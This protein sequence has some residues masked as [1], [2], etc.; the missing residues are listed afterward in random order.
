MEKQYWEVQS[1]HGGS[2][3]ITAAGTLAGGAV[4]FYIGNAVVN[5]NL[6]KY[7]DSDGRF[8]AGK[9]SLVKG[10]SSLSGAA[11]GFALT[12]GWG[13]PTT[14]IIGGSSFNC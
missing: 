1:F 4:G 9:A 12:S 11:A 7:Q 6:D 2:G 3:L 8:K 10:L 13:W 14:L 5:N